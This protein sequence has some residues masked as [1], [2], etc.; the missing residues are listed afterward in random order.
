MP[1]TALYLFIRHPYMLHCVLL[2]LTLK[3]AC[4]QMSS[5]IVIA[6]FFESISFGVSVI[7]FAC[8]KVK[9]LLLKILKSSML[10]P[11]WQRTLKSTFKFFSNHNYLEPN[12]RILKTLLKV[13]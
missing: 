5:K 9:L 3:P 13:R 1:P 11:L 12:Q 10:T 2:R 4:L 7:L 8:N 6:I